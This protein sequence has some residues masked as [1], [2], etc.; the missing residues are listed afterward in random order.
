VAPW[1]NIP[2]GGYTDPAASWQTRWPPLKD[3]DK[4]WRRF[5]GL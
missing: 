4:T 1:N 5:L 2:I 3:H